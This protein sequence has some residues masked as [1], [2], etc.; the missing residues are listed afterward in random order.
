MRR[1]PPLSQ[2]RAFEA[3]ARHRS[4]KLAAEELAVTAA[5]VSHQIRQLEA[6]LGL[7]LFERHTRRVELTAAAH[8]LWPVLRQGLDAFAEALAALAPPRAQA[9]TLAVTPAFAAHWLLPRLPRFQQ[10]HP[11]IELR[12]LASHAVVDLAHGGADLAVRYGGRDEPELE[13]QALPADRFLPVASP[14]LGLRTPADLAAQRLVHFDWHRPAPDRPTWPR[15]LRQSGLRHGDARGGLRFS[16]E[17]HAIQAAV[18]GQ[19]V[20]LLS[21]SLVQDDLARGVLVAP[22][23]PELPA[24]AGRLL[25]QRGNAGPAQQAVW[26]WLAAEFAPPRG[27]GRDRARSVRLRR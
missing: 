25:R 23:G 1:L 22:F 17:S 11:R 2:L 3:A 14:R 12:I 26:D 24:P 18:A 4:F 5:A 21:H 16:E 6:W 15:W 8:S 13:A 20:A 10:L 19:G 9:V 27:H 7:A